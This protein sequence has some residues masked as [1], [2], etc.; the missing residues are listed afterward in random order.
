MSFVSELKRRNVFRAGI[1]YLVVAWL[2]LQVA[3][4]VLDNVPAPSWVMQFFLLAAA[5]GFPVAL[6]L[7]WA[8]EM[9]PEGVKREADVDR[10][11]SITQSTG[12]K[13][14]FTII[15]ILVVAVALFALDKFVWTDSTE[16]AKT[17]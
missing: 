7:A 2:V 14:D 16:N 3:D 4:L 6:L 12:R 5:I 15:G 1:A 8:F 11:Q 9:T 10:T 13:L 17:S